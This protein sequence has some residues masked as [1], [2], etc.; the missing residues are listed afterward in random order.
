M[1]YK[2]KNKHK[3]DRASGSIMTIRPP[4]NKIKVVKPKPKRK[5]NVM[6]DGTIQME[7][8]K[9]YDFNKGGSVQHK[10]HGGKISKYYKGGANVV[11]GRD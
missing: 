10:A 11:T 4:E 7:G 5:Y 2:G 9:K 1:D 3:Y 6:K 8:S